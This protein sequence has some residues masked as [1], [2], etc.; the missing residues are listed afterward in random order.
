MTQIKRSARHPGLCRWLYCFHGHKRYLEPGAEAL[1]EDAGLPP[2][3]NWTRLGHGIQVSDSKI[4]N[5]FRIGDDPR[6]TVFFKRYDYSRYKRWRFFLRTGKAMVEAR[7]YHH[8]QALEIPT[9]EVVAFSE[10]RR[11]GRLISASIVT[12]GIEGAIDLES[13]AG[14]IW[15]TLP[16]AR[17]RQVKTDLEAQFRQQLQRAWSRGFFHQDLQWRN[18]LVQDARG[19]NPQLVWIDCPRAGYKYLRRQYAR[20]VDLSTLSRVPIG[21]FSPH[22]RIRMLARLLGE[23][24]PLKHTRYW[25]RR[26]TAH[27]HRSEP[28]MRRRQQRKKSMEINGVRLD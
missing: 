11:F 13:Y 26:I 2:S 1:I 28:R 18:I 9:L 10:Q 7:G 4:T 15:P 20:L 16:L 8:M 22:V 25:L 24:P 12:R 14:D 19:T 27:H 3:G 21:L 6:E 5:C 17:Q 23:K